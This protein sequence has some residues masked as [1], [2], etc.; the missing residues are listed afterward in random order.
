MFY[1]GNAKAD[2]LANKGMSGAVAG[3]F[4]TTIPL[5]LSDLVQ[6]DSEGYFFHSLSGKMS[7]Y[8]KKKKVES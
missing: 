4:K 7:I 6:V 2:F 1:E 3:F 5:Q 8:P